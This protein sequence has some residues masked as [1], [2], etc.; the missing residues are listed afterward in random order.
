[1][2]RLTQPRFGS[3]TVFAFTLVASSAV[4]GCGPTGFLVTPVPA[5]RSLQERELSRTS[6]LARDKIAIIDVDGLLLNGEMPGLLRRGENPVSM[7]VEKLNA[8]EADKN[9][10]GIVLRINSPGGTVTA[11]EIMHHE[12]ERYKAETGEPVVTVMTDV[13]ASGGYYI[14]CATDY[15]IAYPSS[16]TGSIGVI[17]QMFNVA[18][19]MQK[20]G[21]TGDAIKSGENKDAGSPF[22]E[23]EPDEREIFQGLV[24]QFYERFVA[25][26]H[27]GR[28]A[29]PEDRLRTLAD[30]RVYSAPQA[31]EAGLIDRIGSIYDAIEEVRTRAGLEDY[32]LVGF[33]RPFGWKPNVYAEAPEPAA[34]Q[35]NMINIT[36]PDWLSSLSTPRFMY[37]WSPGS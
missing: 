8:A 7:F 24:M 21:I 32:R 31:L 5:N 13:A 19:T 14:A 34:P 36:L 17:M 1:M 33:E 35:V 30:G 23:M 27:R 28:P 20:L 11:S 4:G 9:V 12:I 22:R 26:V 3:R 37:L 10:K 18:G 25:V 29:I 15:I 2:T 6:W 16:V